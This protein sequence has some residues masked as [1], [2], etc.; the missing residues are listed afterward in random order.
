MYYKCIDSGLATRHFFVLL[1]EIFPKS[2]KVPVHKNDKNHYT[3]M[4]GM[5]KLKNNILQM[6]TFP[7]VLHPIFLL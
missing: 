7:L 1:K 2:I 3:F 6:S 5:V 4:L